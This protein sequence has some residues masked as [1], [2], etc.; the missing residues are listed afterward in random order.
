MP[1]GTHDT[2]VE[3]EDIESNKNNGDDHDGHDN[4][5]CKTHFLVQKWSSQAAHKRL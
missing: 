3:K 2:K 5:I 4:R 1:F